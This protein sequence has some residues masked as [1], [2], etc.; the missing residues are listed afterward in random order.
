MI[1][2]ILRVMANKAFCDFIRLDSALCFFSKMS[3]R[4]GRLPL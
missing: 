1:T 4:N 3:C 2:N